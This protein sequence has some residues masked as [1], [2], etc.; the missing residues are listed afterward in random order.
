MKTKLISLTEAKEMFVIGNCG[1]EWRDDKYKKVGCVE[2][3]GYLVITINGK[4]YYQHR[5][6]WLLVS[7]SWPV[8]QIDH[9]DGNRKNNSIANL[10]QATPSQNQ[11][12]RKCQN[13]TGYSGVTFHK[14]TNKWQAQIKKRGISYYLGLFDSVESAHAAYVDAKKELHLFCPTI[15]GAA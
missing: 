5:I 13:K 9:I 8:N 4:Q 14:K 3:T 2:K 11:E 7:G 15:R 10:R 1:L 6:V 12:N